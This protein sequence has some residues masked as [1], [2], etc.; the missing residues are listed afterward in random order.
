M[1]KTQVRSG[2]ISPLII[3]ALVIVI[4]IGGLL[5]WQQVRQTISSQTNYSTATNGY[6]IGKK[7]TVSKTTKALWRFDGQNWQGKVAT[8]ANCDD[9]A[10]L[11]SSLS[12]DLSLA[13]ARLYPGQTRGNDYKAHGGLIFDNQRNLVRIN[14]PVDAT[15]YEGSRY[16]EMG[17]EQILIDLQTDCGWLLRFDHLA[18]VGPELADSI[19]ELPA[20]LADQSQTHPIDPVRLQ[21]GTLIASEIGFKKLNRTTVDFGLYNLK[22]KNQVSQ[23]ANWQ[24]EHSELQQLGAHGVCW[25][26]Y[27]IPADQALVNKLPAGDSAAGALSDY[28]E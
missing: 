10:P 15:L 25:F 13:T 18:K 9:N 17:E 12:Q 11:T 1:E 7:S 6:G 28:C 21:A 27:L 22:Q 20:P 24:K 4:V 5:T 19:A 16:L 26:D 3:I 2:I 14:L 8:G 23:T